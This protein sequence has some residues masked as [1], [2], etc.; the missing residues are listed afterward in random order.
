MCVIKLDE[1]KIII[2]VGGE[3]FSLDIIG[4][5]GKVLSLGIIGVGS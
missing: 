5:G 2:G 3:V 4:V 1:G